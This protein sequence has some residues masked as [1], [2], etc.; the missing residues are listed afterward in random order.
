V[1][2]IGEIEKAWGQVLVLLSCGSDVHIV[3]ADIS[4][5]Q[6]SKVWLE[7]AGAGGKAD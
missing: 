2:A 4:M 1:P 5:N 6:P 3:R 7:L